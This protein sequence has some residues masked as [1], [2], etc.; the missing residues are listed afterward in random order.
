MCESDEK[1]EKK[2][3]ER[4]PTSERM[5]EG[6]VAD[7]LHDHHHHHHHNHI[8]IDVIVIS[9]RGRRRRFSNLP[10]FFSSSSRIS[11]N[12]D[13]FVFLAEKYIDRT[14]TMK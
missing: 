6:K 10:F 14:V 5:T 12:E 4:R 2:K 13:K 11:F 8:A 3:N 7:H 1:E 9:L